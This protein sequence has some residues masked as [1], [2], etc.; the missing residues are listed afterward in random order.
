MVENNMDDEKVI[1]SQKKNSKEI[2]NVYNKNNQQ[3]KKKFQKIM[4]AFSTKIQ[5]RVNK[6]KKKLDR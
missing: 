3:K 2:Q 5:K 4:D 6:I 1:L